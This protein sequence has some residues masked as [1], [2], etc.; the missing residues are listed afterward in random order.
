MHHIDI[1]NQRFERLLALETTGRDTSGV[2][3]WRCKCDCGKIVITRGT[4]LRNGTTRSCG[5]LKNRLTG[6]LKYSFKHGGK[7][8]HTREYSSWQAMKTRCL[9]HNVKSFRDYGARGI[10]ICE[11]WMNSFENFLADMGKKPEGTTLDRINNNGNYDPSNCRWASRSEQNSNQRPRHR[12]S[13]PHNTRLNVD[14]IRDIRSRRSESR[15]QLAAEFG[16]S[17]S[18]VT[19]IINGRRWQRVDAGETVSAQSNAQ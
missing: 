2:R 13:P 9:N 3:M 12:S 17:Y 7:K 14:Q 11:R 8:L 5:C 18:H 15:R 4:A 10:K 6:S 1:S 16:I 19:S